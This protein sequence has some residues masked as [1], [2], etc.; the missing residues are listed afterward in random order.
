[1]KRKQT[2]CM[3]TGRLCVCAQCQQ[4]PPSQSPSQRPQ[5]RVSAFAA[6]L[7]LRAVGSPS[8]QQAVA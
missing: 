4:S 3:G 7:A 6:T 8:G 1:M 2:G 5:A